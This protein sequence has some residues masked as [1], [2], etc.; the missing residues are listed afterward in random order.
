MIPKSTTLVFLGRSGCGKD[1]QIE[2]LLRREEVKDAVKI[3]MG[4]AFRE[5]A[6]K[7]TIFGRKIKQILDEGERQ[8]WW[9]GALFCIPGLEPF[10]DKE[11]LL[12]DGPPG[13]RGFSLSARVSSREIQRC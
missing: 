1:T 13:M 8:P 3:V 5:L 4:D 10:A 2:F 12:I 11:P 7:K 6:Q 9:L